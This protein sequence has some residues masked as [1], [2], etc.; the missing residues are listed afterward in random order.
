MTDEIKKTVEDVLD[1]KLNK[2]IAKQL[3]KLTTKKDKPNPNIIADEILRQERIITF[4]DTDEIFVYNELSGLYEPAKNRI[5][6]QIQSTQDIQTSRY[7]IEGALASIRR[8]TRID[9]NAIAANT[10]KIPLS[11]GI[12][13]FVKKKLEDYNSDFVFLKKHP[14]EY[15]SPESFDALFENPIDTFLVEVAENVEDIVLLKELVGY[16]FYRKMP[17]QNI[18]LLVGAGANGKSVFLQ[19]LTAMLGKDNVSTESLQ[20]LSSNR[21]SKVNLYLKNANIFGDLPSKALADVGIL[22]QATGGDSL[23]AE[24]KFKNR[25]NF[26]NYAKIIASCN[27]IPETPDYTDGFFRRFVIINFPNCFEGKEN[28]NLAHELCQPTNLSHFFDSCIDAFHEAL[29]QNSMIR[30]EQTNVK[31]HK[32]LLYSSSPVAFCDSHLNYDPE[33]EL[34]TDFVYKK[35]KEYCLANKAPLKDERLFFKKLYECFGHK[36]YKK[37]KRETGFDKEVR[38]FVIVGLDYKD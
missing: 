21:F 34:E 33:S 28:R 1:E 31:K 27:E 4:E 15:K 10:D 29:L 19:V 22:K 35:Y 26:V 32:Y 5:E 8:R 17:F 6:S 20:E 36:V 7:L 13:D 14:I 30:S 9:R 25:F 11:N 37:R 18:F 23:P 38:F 2:A 3:E 24:Q 12:Y 16:C